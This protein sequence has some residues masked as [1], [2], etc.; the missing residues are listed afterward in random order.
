MFKSSSKAIIAA[1]L[2]LLILIVVYQ[3]N[4]KPYQAVRLARQAKAAEKAGDFQAAFILYQK[5]LTKTS[6]QSL[7]IRRNLGQFVSDMLAEQSHPQFSEQVLEYAVGEIQKNIKLEPLEVKNY[8]LLGHVYNQAFWLDEVYLNKSYKALKKAQTLSPY[9]VQTLQE[10]GYNFYLKRDLNEA[11]KWLEKARQIRDEQGIL[12]W[13]LGLVYYQK[14]DFSKALEFFEEAIA[15]GYS[16][17]NIHAYVQLASAYGEVGQFQKAVFFYLKAIEKDPKN[18]Q[19]Y[20]SLAAAYKELGD[21]S[22]AIESA[23]K[24]AELDPGF[25]S[26]AQRFIRTLRK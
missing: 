18:P 19:L 25:S 15:R 4:L 22:K 8:L 24:A 12:S 16:Y 1:V 17:T 7:H 26:E 2:L 6:L 5:A 9:R 11:I 21:F 10:I 20:A 23:Q 14:K 13:K 3:L